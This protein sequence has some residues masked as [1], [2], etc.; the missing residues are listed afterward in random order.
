MQQR[1]DRILEAADTRPHAAALNPERVAGVPELLGGDPALQ[2]ELL[3]EA[4][5][6]LGAGTT[7]EGRLYLPSL[8]R[9]LLAARPPLS[10]EQATVLLYAAARRNL[11]EDLPLN[12]VVGEIEALPKPL[13]PAVRDALAAFDT[14][15][16]AALR[17]KPY[18]KLAPRLT[19]LLGVSPADVVETGG[20]FS[21]AVFAQLE[22]LDPAEAVAWRELFQSGF[23]LAAARPS[24]KWQAHAKALVERIGAETFRAR[25]KAW[26][27]LGPTPGGAE[28][29]YVPDTDVPFLRALVFAIGAVRAAGLAG[30]VGD[31]ALAC[32]Q[33]IRNRGPVCLAAGNAC[34]WTLGE[35]GLD[36][37]GQLGL[38]KMR[39]KYAVAL[40]LIEKALE[41]AARRAGVTPE[42][43]EEIGVPT[44]ELETRSDVELVD[45]VRVKTADKALKRDIEAM[46]AAQRLR[47]ERMYLTGRTW[48]VATWRKRFFDH[49]LLKSIVRRLVW[50]AGDASFAWDGERF[51]DAGGA[52]FE[53]SGEL[54]LWHPVD[55]RQEAWSKRGLTTPFKQID[56]ETFSLDGARETNRFAGRRVSQHRFHALCRERGWHYRLQGE[57]DSQNDAVL[58][59]PKWGL[60]AT[61]EVAPPHATGV[62]PAG[63]YQQVETGNVQ[64]QYGESEDV[65]ARVISEVL[66]DVSLF[67]GD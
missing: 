24:A 44:F 40:R 28:D 6:Q 67:A 18:Q 26:L 19:A 27:A 46:L 21:E 42:D 64:L 34:L 10:A 5:A 12:D 50:R 63:I 59:L 13:P 7:I 1:L 9:L 31:F 55:G 49:P 65:P 48:P 33:K 22:K 45:G 53:P 2:A 52:A 62:T 16:R 29:A 14:A 32:Y 61:L 3:V 57:F 56:R 66:R 36:G 39:V 37:V 38:L 20:A 17:M 35:V 47:L 54:T 41:D 25:A 4:V 58:E 23:T 51:I 43:L 8:V 30:A 60:R 15:A 11:I